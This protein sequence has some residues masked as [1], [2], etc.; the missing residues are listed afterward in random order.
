MNASRERFQFASAPDSW[1]VLDYPGSSW[2]QSYEKMLDE[3]VGAGY[4]G[5]ELGPYGFFPTDPKILQLQLDKR[6][7]KL[8]A[9][10]VPVRMT[11]PGAST[12]V[13]ERIRKV[14]DL[15]STLKAPF[16][17]LA[18]AQS[19][20]RN[21]YSGRASDKGCPK[22]SAEQ[23]KHIGKIVADAEK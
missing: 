5:T 19:N 8:L 14:G 2:E 16:L 20:E 7:L 6:K 15:L 3:M 9:S 18:D 12:A 22:L 13:I 4:T 11:D 21:A 10:F 23:W 1:G 17:A